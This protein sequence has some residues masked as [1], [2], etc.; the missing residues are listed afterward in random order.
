MAQA[1]HS[2]AIAAEHAAVA[3]AAAFYHRHLGG[4]GQLIDVSIH[5]AC[6]QSTEATVHRYIY[7]GRNQVR[8]PPQQMRSADGRFLAVVVVLLRMANLPKLVELLTDSGLGQELKDPRFRDTAYLRSAEAT[9]TIAATLRKWVA[10][11]TVEEAFHGLQNCAVLC[12]PVRPPEDL[13][14]DPQSRERGDF[15]EVEH[16]ELGKRF[17]YPRHPRSQT[18]TP[19]RWGPRAPLLGEHNSELWSE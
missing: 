8:N 12:G 17:I 10:T 18:E 16:P 5:D 13:L 7:K 15:V 9:G 14:D 11:K 2:Y 1:W 3:I 6:A 19:W 4:P